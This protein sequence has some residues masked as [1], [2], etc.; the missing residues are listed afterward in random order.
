M[1]EIPEMIIPS[2][3]STIA[4][5]TIIAFVAIAFVLGVCS[6][7]E[8]NQPPAARK[9]RGLIAAVGMS[10]WLIVNA[11]LP[12]S[13]VFET[14]MIPPPGMIFFVF[15]FTLAFVVAFSR[16]GKRLAALPF[17]ALVGFH[18]FRFPLELVLHNW[19]EAGTLPV[20]MTYEGHNLDIVTGL[21]AIA[22]GAWAVTGRAPRAAIWFFNIV[23]SLLLWGVIFIAVTSSPVPIRQ[24]MNDPPVLLLFHFPYSWIVSVAVTGAMIG[25]FILFRRLFDHTN[26][27]SGYSE[28]QGSNNNS[29]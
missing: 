4:F 18:G 5:V 1:P 10:V 21:L 2:F 7:G 24:Y 6:G 14:D 13:R 3:A 28:D 27:N 29:F 17:A 20:Q 11:V 12:I 9:R 8:D 23:G 22:I 19:Y 16:L 26:E 25:H 15:C